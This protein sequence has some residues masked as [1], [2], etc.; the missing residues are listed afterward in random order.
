VSASAR[1]SKVTN[2]DIERIVRIVE[3]VALDAGLVA[4]EHP[5]KE[6]EESL[7]E[8]YGFR[9]IASYQHLTGRRGLYFSVTVPN[10]D[11]EID[12]VIRDFDHADETDLTRRLKEEVN[13]RLR[14]EF[15]GYRIEVTESQIDA[16]LAP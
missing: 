1:D 14:D 5:S 15:T 9:P 8:T 3:S 16:S 7:V 10:G 13:R 12:I 6:L 11:L 4:R 2:S